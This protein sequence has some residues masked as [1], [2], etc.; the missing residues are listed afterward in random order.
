MGIKMGEDSG[1]I[2]VYRCKKCKHF[3]ISRHGLP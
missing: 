3:R 2:R 1:L